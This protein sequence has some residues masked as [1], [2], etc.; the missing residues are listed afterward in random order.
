MRETVLRSVVG[1]DMTPV[2]AEI[3]AKMTRQTK[4]GV[5]WDEGNI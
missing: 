3:R 4:R 1:V 5:D 2:K